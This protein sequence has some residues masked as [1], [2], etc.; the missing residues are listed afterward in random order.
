MYASYDYYKGTYLGNLIPEQD[1]ARVALR[2]D[3]YLDYYTMCKVKNHTELDAVKMAACALAE[4]YY[5]MDQLPV[6]SG[7]Q[8]ETVGSYSVTYRSAE[9]IQRIK[10]VLP[11]IVRMHL[12]GTGLLYRGRC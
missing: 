2:A 6:A 3:Q 9:D 1:Y 8:S 5:E 12:A 11:N 4:Q 10:L 7:K